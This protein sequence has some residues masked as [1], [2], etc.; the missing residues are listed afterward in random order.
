MLHR[1]APAQRAGIAGGLGVVAPDHVTADQAGL[2][3]KE[4]GTSPQVAPSSWNGPRRPLRLGF[5]HRLSATWNL[6]SFDWIQ[7][8]NVRSHLI[9]FN[10]AIF[11]I[12]QRPGTGCRYPIKSW[13]APTVV[14]RRNSRSVE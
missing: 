12:R 9:G 14:R 10:L 2:S 11:L 6:V 8:E 3:S 4:A 13:L 7:K 5:L 1:H